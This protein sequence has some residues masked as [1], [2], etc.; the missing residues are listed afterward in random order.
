MLEAYYRI[1]RIEG[2]YAYLRNENEPEKEETVEQKEPEKT[3]EE[4]PEEPP[5]KDI[6][7]I[8]SGGYKLWVSVAVRAFSS[9]I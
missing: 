4:N 8:K 6:V 5:V 7:N 1:V 3:E 2:E 9:T